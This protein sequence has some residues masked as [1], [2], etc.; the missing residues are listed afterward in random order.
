MKIGDKF[1]INPD[2]SISDDYPDSPGYIPELEAYRGQVVTV[3]QV[4]VEDVGGK[5]HDD[6]FTAKGNP[7]TWSLRWVTEVNEKEIEEISDE[8]FSALLK[9]DWNGK[10]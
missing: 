10:V 7:W 5:K 6:W 8:E 1:I 2:L 9:G 3:E 4:A